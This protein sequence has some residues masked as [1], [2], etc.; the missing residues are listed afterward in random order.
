MKPLAPREKKI[1]TATILAVGIAILSFA[2][3]EG[4]NLF[5][6]SLFQVPR[7]G[8]FWLETSI[9][10]PKRM[11]AS[12]KDVILHRH[13]AAASVKWPQSGRVAAGNCEPHDHRGR[14]IPCG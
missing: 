6:V 9:L 5:G 1:V 11:L 8:D 13:T 14:G 4:D 10:G 3:I 7:H 2:V 12:K